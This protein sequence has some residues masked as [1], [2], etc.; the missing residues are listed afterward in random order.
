M[1]REHLRPWKILLVMRMWALLVVVKLALWRYPLFEVV[2]RLA[3]PPKRLR[4]P[5]L[6]PYRLSWI[7][8]RVLLTRFWR[9][10]CLLRSLVHLRCLRVQGDRAELVIGLPRETS[11]T[12]AHAWVELD[13]AVVGP[14]P[15]KAGHEELVRYPVR[16]GQRIG[17]P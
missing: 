5:R 17:S 4:R 7:N 15:G 11:A 13:G 1:I 12:D 9:P 14:A 6:D 8:N 10:R 2:D 16:P 3:R